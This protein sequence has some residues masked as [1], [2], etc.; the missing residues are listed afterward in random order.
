[1]ARLSESSMC[2]LVCFVEYSYGRGLGV[3]LGECV[4]RPSKRISPKRDG[5]LMLRF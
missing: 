4:A 2:V 1:M 5:L 3:V